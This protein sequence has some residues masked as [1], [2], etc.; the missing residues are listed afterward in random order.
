MPLSFND[1]TNSSLRLL[2]TSSSPQAIH[3]SL[4]RALVAAGSATTACATSCDGGP[5]LNAGNQ[6]NLSI[7]PMHPVS[8]LPPPTLRPVAAHCCG[9]HATGYSNANSGRALENRFLR[10]DDIAGSGRCDAAL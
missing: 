10:K 6:A 5:A 7:F 4:S 3:K 1:A 8:A 9:V 2:R